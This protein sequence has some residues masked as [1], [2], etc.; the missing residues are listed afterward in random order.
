MKLICPLCQAPLAELEGGVGCA[1]GHRFD[2]ARQGY[3]NL[4]PV[5]HK[6]SL[7]PGDNAAMVEARR[8]FLD[9]GHYAPLAERLAQLAVTMGAVPADYFK[10]Y[11]FEDEVL[12][13]LRAKPTTRAE[14]ILSWAPGY[15]DHYREQVTAAEPHLDPAR[16]RGGIHEL[17]LAIDVMDAVFNGK[18]EIHPVN[19]PN[20]GGVLPGLPEDLVVEVYGRTVDG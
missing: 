2:R 17:E 1:V 7:D 19:V 3:L 14:D 18:D 15:W 12:A 13:E 8:R 4:L 5:Q 20:R 16:P 6:K 9:A 11:Y 10:Y